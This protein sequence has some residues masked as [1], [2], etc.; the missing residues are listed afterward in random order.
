[1]LAHKAK[2]I[3]TPA[4][5]LVPSTRRVP[6]GLTA[7]SPQLFAPLLKVWKLERSSSN[8][9]SWQLSKLRESSRK[10]RWQAAN[11]VK[12]RKSPL[13]AYTKH[14]ATVCRSQLPSPLMRRCF[15]RAGS[16]KC[17]SLFCTFTQRRNQRD[18]A[19]FVAKK[20]ELFSLCDERSNGA[21]SER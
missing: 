3:R 10:I 9:P 21:P 7:P 4:R 15:Q 12:H 11:H 2:P 20:G 1:M 18:S 14:D 13:N 19:S 6:S 17:R 16:L 5:T 8:H